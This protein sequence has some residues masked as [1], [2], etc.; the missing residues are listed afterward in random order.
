MWHLDF[1]D[2]LDFDLNSEINR[3]KPPMPRRAEEINSG[4]V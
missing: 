2:R 3:E 4:G 1:L